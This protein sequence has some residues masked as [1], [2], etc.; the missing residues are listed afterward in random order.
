MLDFYYKY[1]KDKL[2]HKATA[3]SKEL[4]SLLSLKG[5]DVLIANHYVINEKYTQLIGNELFEQINNIYFTIK[6]VAYDDILLSKY[7]DSNKSQNHDS[8]LRFADFFCG[9]GGLSEGIIQSGFD[10]A[11]VNDHNIQALE[12]YYFNHNLCVDS[13]YGGN[14]ETLADDMSSYSHLFHDIKLVSGGPPCQG[15]SMANRQ[16]LQNDKRNK[17]YRFFLT[18]ISEINPEWFVMEN[19][20]GLKNKEREVEDDIR[21][22]TDDRYRFCSLLLNA[23]DFGVPQNRERY[24]LIG[25]RIGVPPEQ[26]VAKLDAAKRS[27]K[28]YFLR[29]ALFGLPPITT[30]PHIRSSHLDSDDHGYTLRRI[31]TELNDFITDINLGQESDLLLNHK[32]RYNN[33]ND[34]EIFRRLMP[35][36]DSTAD[37]IQDILKYK[38]RKDIFKDK[39]KKLKDDEVC[40]TITSHMRLDCHMYIHPSQARGLSPRE[41]ARIQSFP[42]NYFFRG[43][44]NDWYYQ[45]GNA[46]PVKLSKAIAE[47]IKSFYK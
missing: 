1:H 25:N 39:Y 3:L 5:I 33:N 24:F 23:K 26:V 21:H 20:R 7:L 9:A 15:F 16:P 8:E 35:G 36:E 45:I 37:S 4:S 42:D 22:I 12:T 43:S 47:T 2:I 19:V 18:M 46:V 40:K 34:I 44:L 6:N 27:C 28:E 13:F 11:F 17:L 32:S 14:I 31:T 30:N 38:N 29:D 10:P 41:A